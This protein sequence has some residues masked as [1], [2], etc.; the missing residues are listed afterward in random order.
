MIVIQ[1]PVPRV[2][3]IVL[4]SRPEVGVVAQIVEV[5]IVVVAV[6][7]RKRGIKAAAVPCEMIIAKIQ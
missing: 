2:I 7:G 6:T 5:T 4:R 3:C 1:V